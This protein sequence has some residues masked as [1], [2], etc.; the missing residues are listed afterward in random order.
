[1]ANDNQEFEEI[2]GELAQFSDYKIGDIITYRSPDGPIRQ[3]EIMWIESAGTTAS[4]KHHPLTYW[5][6]FDAVYATD[7]VT[8]N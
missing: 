6:G 4:G 5:C 3:G 8:E 2:F 7:I 1:M